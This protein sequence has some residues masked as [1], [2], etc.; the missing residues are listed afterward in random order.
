MHMKVCC[1]LFSAALVYSL[2]CM[3]MPFCWTNMKLQ[4]PFQQAC[5]FAHRAEHDGGQTDVI[6][7]SSVLWLHPKKGEY[8]GADPYFTL[9]LE[10]KPRTATITVLLLILFWWSSYISLPLRLKF[11]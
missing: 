3:E 6:N 1:L 2:M 11:L 9:N 10:K 8:T 5:V 7:H 4:E